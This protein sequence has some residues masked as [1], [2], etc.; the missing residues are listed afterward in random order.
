M[1]SIPM[2]S[3]L[4]GFRKAVETLKLY[5]RAKLELVGEQSEASLIEQLYVDPKPG[6]QVLTTLLQPNSTLVIGRK[7][8]GKSTIFQRLQHELRSS[9]DT[10]SY[11]IWTPKKSS[12]QASNALLHW[13]SGP[14]LYPVAGE[15]L[16]RIRIRY[17]PQATRRR[18]HNRAAKAYSGRLLMTVHGPKPV[19]SVHARHVGAGTR[20]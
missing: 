13:R 5:R 18:V 20:A 6:G 3:P 7:G 9:R 17:R 11:H 2:S 1:T 12:N 14:P 16:H 4:E 8:I 10:T 19:I 15:A